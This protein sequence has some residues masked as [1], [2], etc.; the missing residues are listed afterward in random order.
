MRPYDRPSCGSVGGEACVGEESQTLG[1]VIEAPAPAQRCFSEACGNAPRSSSHLV[2]RKKGVQH[3]DRSV[4]IRPRAG[5]HTR[6]CPPSQC[7]L[8]R[9]RGRGRKCRCPCHC[10]CCFGCSS[11][12]F[13]TVHTYGLLVSS[14]KSTSND[15]VL[16]IFSGS[17]PVQSRRSHFFVLR[18]SR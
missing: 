6:R 10:S 4:G 12:G 5:I 2:A 17:A 11:A 1:P 16:Q 18:S 15:R 13:G 7:R 9:S 14:R 8:F 3:V